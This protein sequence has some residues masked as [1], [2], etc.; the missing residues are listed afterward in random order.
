MVQNPGHLKNAFHFS[1][2]YL[3]TRHDDKI[4]SYMDYGIPLGRRFRCLKLWFALKYH[5][6][7]F[8]K[9]KIRQQ[10][11]YS[12][13][14]YKTLDHSPEFEI[15]APRPLSTTCFRALP[16]TDENIDQYNERLMDSINQTGKFFIS[17]T[18]LNDKFVLRHVVS[19]F[20]TTS[21]H[22][23]DFLTHL[24]DIKKTLD[25]R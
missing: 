16:R 23:E 17:H 4:E 15:V 6:V 14:V 5:G 7:A 25:K 21:K 10:I 8:Y 18:K 20:K 3:K 2:E 12:E 11:E 22:I 1:A 13:T 9:E 24:L 19:G